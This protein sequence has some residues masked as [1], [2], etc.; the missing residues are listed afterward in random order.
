MFEK[1]KNLFTT[2]DNSIRLLSPVAGE[3]VPLSRV[4]DPTFSEEMLGKGAAVIPSDGRIVS[5]VDGK[6]LGIFKT[7]HAVTLRSDDGAEI[8]IHIGLDTV[9]LGGQHFTPHV[10]KGDIVKA[11]QLMIEADIK[12]IEAEGYNTITPVLVCN[13][14]EYSS[15]EGVF[16]TVPSLGELIVLQRK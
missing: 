3:A 11:G 5:P 12:A 9:K 4:P 16:G 1:L 2:T 13:T 8:L 10:K 7:C 6:V 15:V 14:D